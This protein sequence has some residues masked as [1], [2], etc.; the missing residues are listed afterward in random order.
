M[1]NIFRFLLS[2]QV[3]SFKRGY[4]DNFSLSI[5][6]HETER[7]LART[8][9]VNKINIQEYPPNKGKV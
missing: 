2:V 4:R 8:K 3:L 6:L 5:E 9:V 7:T 1:V